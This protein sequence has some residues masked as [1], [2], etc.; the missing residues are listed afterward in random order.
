MRELGDKQGIA[1]SL[2]NLGDVALQQGDYLAA[3][4]FLQECLTLCREL[5]DK[6]GAFVAL[7]NCAILARRRQ[8]PA[9]AVQLWSVAT[10]GR[11]AICFPLPPFEREIQEREMTAAREAL[12]EEAFAAAWAR[13][14]TMTI[15]Q[16]TE[17]ALDEK[18]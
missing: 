12:G 17:Y 16:A 6:E 1:N 2:S 18:A 14:Q 4:A 7:E 3:H 10:T 5:G 9:Q 15:E 8:Y 11:E 13:G